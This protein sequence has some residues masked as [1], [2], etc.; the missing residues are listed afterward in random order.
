M[1]AA[2][3]G[4][5][6]GR[7][8]GLAPRAPPTVHADPGPRTSLLPGRLRAGS[9]ARLRRG[10]RLRADG[11]AAAEPGRLLQRLGA[12]VRHGVRADHPQARRHPVRADRP[13]RRL[14]RG[15]RGR[16]LRRV[17]AH[18]RRPRPRLRA[19]RGHRVRAR[20]ERP[21]VL[22]GLRAHPA[23]HLRGRVAAHRDA[24]PRP[25]RR[26][27][28]LAVDA[29]G[30]RAGHRA[31]RVL[32]A[33]CPVRHLGR[34][35][36]LLLPSQ[37]HVRHRLRQ[38]HRPGPV[39]H[40]QAGAALGDRGGPARQAS[41]RRSRTCSTAWPQYKTLGLVWFDKPQHG[42]LYHQDWRIEDNVQAEIS[43]RLGVRDELAPY[44]PSS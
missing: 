32:V 44:R 5:A 3:L 31:G 34:H 36:R 39:L 24:V 40:R 28:H 7:L 11:G 19:R 14:G 33:G 10:R 21:L 9:A 8:I 16:H 27:R 41:S 37:R 2:A 23:R 4:A 1:A 6:A 29:P 15:H 25:G 18:L 26:E 12:A 20:D 22:V 30:G 38:D 13:D 17:P 43:F 35:R 42:G